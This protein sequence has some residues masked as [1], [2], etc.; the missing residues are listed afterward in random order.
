MKASQVESVG[1]LCPRFTPRNF[2]VVPVTVVPVVYAMLHHVLP[3]TH[4]LPA[5]WHTTRLG[6]ASSRSRASSAE[7]WRRVA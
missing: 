7:P 6:A 5:V 3:V 2:G 1:C 4:E